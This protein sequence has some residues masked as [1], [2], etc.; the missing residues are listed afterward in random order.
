MV[1]TGDL[2]SP[3]KKSPVSVRLRYPALFDTIADMLESVDNP[4]LGSGA[5]KA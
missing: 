2:K 3:G 4:D 1:A 5:E